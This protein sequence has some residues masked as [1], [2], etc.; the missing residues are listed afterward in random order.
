[1]KLLTIRI[2][3]SSLQLAEA[4]HNGKKLLIQKMRMFALPENLESGGFLQDPTAMADFIAS[5][6]ERGK[7]SGGKAILLLDVASVML[8]EY[9]HEKTKP[10]VLLSLA[11]LEAEAVLPDNEGEFI[12][13]NEW[14]GGRLNKDG[15]Q[16]SAIYAANERFI[17]EIGKEC[18]KKGVKLAAVFPAST[19]HTELVRLLLDS[20][21]S[22]SEFSEKTIAAIDLS[23]Q[24]I[25][26]A[27]FHN[28]DLVHQRADDL[29]LEEFYRGAAAVYMIPV[30]EAEDYCLKYGFREKGSGG[31]LDLPSL[32]ALYQAGGS[33]ITKLLRSVNVILTAEELQLDAVVI[34]G[35]AAAIPGMP[36]IVAESTG[37]PCKSIDEYYEML[38][39]TIVLDDELKERENLFQRL[40]LLCGIDYR[41]K[42]N[43]NFL[44]R[45]IARK[46]NNRRTL[47]VCTLIL[48]CTFLVMAIL[49]L[50][51]L[52]TSR[53][54]RNNQQAVSSPKY[55]SAQALLEEQRQLQNAIQAMKAE[56]NSLPFGQSNT[57]DML[58]ELQAKLF[59]GCRINNLV[60]DRGNDT[61]HVIFSTSKLDDFVAAKNRLNEGGRFQVSLPLTI[62][63]SDNLWQCQISIRVLPQNA[64]EE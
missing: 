63:S 52:I 24:E 61:F 2:E 5:C 58:G 27:V 4:D 51:Y 1:M 28:R 22:G 33:F 47:V 13:E 30:E 42:K 21:I 10:S 14:Y 7:L 23:H 37:I 35:T 15:L 20:R 26:V 9:T 19:V 50:N 31:I 25:R 57:A 41:K 34:S 32:E 36:E 3:K 18:R 11:V 49:P 56:T 43:L 44:M 6:I 17:S 54:Y 53:D 40:F 38:S 12:I 29:L 16:K 55:Q 8:K 48:I 46:R 45:G 59:V 64:E 62:N 39:D 60:Y